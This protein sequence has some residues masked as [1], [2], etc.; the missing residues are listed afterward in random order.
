MG[1]NKFYVI[2]I[3]GYKIVREA[4]TERVWFLEKSQINA[5][6]QNFQYIST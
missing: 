5:I 2:N 6:K 4:V 1:W 3:V